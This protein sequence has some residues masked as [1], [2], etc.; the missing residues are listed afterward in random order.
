MPGSLAAA[1]KWAVDMC[2]RA[3]VGYYQLPYREGVRHN[4]ITYYD[5]SSFIFYA[6][7][8]AGFSVSG[9][10]F[11][12]LGMP[13]VLTGLG[14]THYTAGSDFVWK[15]G[16]IGLSTDHTEMCYKG[17]TGKAI[18]MGA[19]GRNGVALANQV[20]IGDRYGNATATR[21]FPNCWRLE[22]QEITTGPS[23]YVIAAICGNF[24]RESNINP[25]I[26]ESLTP[27]NWDD[28][29]S[30]NTGG[31]GLGQWTN[32]NGD[33]HG[34]LYKLHLWLSANGYADDSLEG[35][36]KYIL[37]EKYWA[38]NMN[39]SRLTSFM[40]SESTDLYNL[41]QLWNYNWEGINDGTLDERY[42]HAQAV[43]NYILQHKDDTGLQAVSG[44]KYLTEAQILNNAVCVY[45]ALS[46][47][48]ISYVQLEEKEPKKKKM[49]VW[50]MVRK[51]I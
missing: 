27:K 8:A 48:T 17:G 26:W 40:N 19:H 43:Y 49:P 45:K 1:Y 42:Q 34:R 31:Y 38:G 12:T 22:T 16:D 13:K 3:D 11:T 46:G 14:F 10:A 25:G 28:V 39:D 21:T 23:L 2:N 47:A 32:T 7:K 24:W 29:W 5:C 35:Q 20:S 15:P 41:T 4:G 51:R 37:Q 30:N 33:T 18:F 50:M 44:N 6:L 9:G 36:A